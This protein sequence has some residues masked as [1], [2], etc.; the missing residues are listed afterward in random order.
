[1]KTL[2]FEDV[3]VSEYKG[4]TVDVAGINVTSQP[5]MLVIGGEY[6]DEPDMCVEVRYAVDED[7]NDVTQ[8]VARAIAELLG[9]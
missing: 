8:D 6:R 2:K 5:S 9:K 3:H 1:V 4:E 7:G